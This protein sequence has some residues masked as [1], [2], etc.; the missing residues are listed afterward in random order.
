MASNRAMKKPGIAALL[1]DLFFR[2]ETKPVVVTQP[3]IKPKGIVADINGYTAGQQQEL[4][5]LCGQLFKKKSLITTG[6]LQ[7]IGL[8]KIRR[9]LGNRWDE[10]KAFVYKV[11]KDV[12]TEKI[13][14]GDILVRMKDDTYLI[15]F[16]E[17]TLSQGNARS[18]EIADEIR[19]RLFTSTVE[20]MRTISV[21][22]CVVETRTKDFSTMSFSR[23]LD[24]LTSRRDG[25]QQPAP[26]AAPPVLTNA[27]LQE[28][29]RP[30]TEMPVLYTPLWDHKNNAITTYFCYAETSSTISSGLT[31]DLSLLQKA[32]QETARM[33]ADGRKFFVMCPVKHETLYKQSS[34]AIY[35]KK[36]GEMTDAQ[37]K[38]LIFV[39]TDVREE[40]RKANGY[41]F[42]PQLKGECQH[43]FLESM[44]SSAFDLSGLGRMG[45]DGVGINIKN[46]G[47]SEQQTMDRLLELRDKCNAAGIQKTFVRGLSTLSMTMF[48]VCNGFDYLGGKAVHEPVT[49]PDG[50]HR[51]RYQDIVY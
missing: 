24:F 37:R 43:L 12:I 32:Q 18:S 17:A 11:A 1:R 5:Y 46:G 45:F 25:A 30:L 6:K 8:E 16:S 35:K 22:K 2:K 27:R 39:V 10:Q 33:V 7:L 20:E 26:Q 44:S 29:A 23:A 41:W 31:L 9:S 47:D 28:E 4:E 48:A 42:A 21:Q 34:F 3:K 49:F 15:I 50:I 51:Y 36:C 13:G 14:D 19:K 38:M 40:W